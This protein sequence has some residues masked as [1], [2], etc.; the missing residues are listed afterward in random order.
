M[1]TR[2]FTLS[3]LILIVTI[4]ARASHNVVAYGATPND[5][6][7]DTAA[8]QTTLNEAAAAGGGQVDIPSGIYITSDTLL[9]PSNVHVKG[10][11]RGA[12]IIRPT[13]GPYPGKVVN[14]AY[15]FASL[16]MV[17]VSRASV[18]SLTL[19]HAT[20]QTQANGIAITVDGTNT[21]SLYCTISDAEVLSFDSYQYLIWNHRGKHTKILNNYVDGGV[22]FYSPSSAQEGIEVFGG[23]DV[24]VQGNTVRNIGGNALYVNPEALVGPVLGLI[25]LRNYIN[26]AKTGI[27]MAAGSDIHGAQIKE[28]QVLSPWEYGIAV[29][30]SNGITVDDLQIS[31]NSVNGGLEGI[32]LIGEPGVIARTISFRNNHVTKAGGTA[33]G[34]IVLNYFD[35]VELDGNTVSDGAGHGIF[36]SACKNVTVT[37]NRVEAVQQIGILIENSHSVVVKRNRL[38]DYNLANNTSSGIYL[39]LTIKGIVRDNEFSVTNQSYAVNVPSAASDQIVIADNDLLYKATFNP[40]FVNLGTNPNFGSMIFAANETSKTVTNTLVNRSSSIVISQ[41]SGAPLAY[42]VTQTNGAFTVSLNY[43]PPGGETLK[44]E[45]R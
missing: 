9:I 22:P 4:S 15:V 3:F 17:S 20:N 18:E 29:T 6:T 44:W 45:I 26:S 37:N 16:A 40:V 34:S 28:N 2:I 12:T 5:A 13:G 33:A 32:R 35:N 38:K 43:Y 25:V 39:P 11:G 41:I 21:P 27:R 23:E 19:D 36:A 10:E 1:I 31:G 14:G 7:D 42:I 30:A 8:I 24:L